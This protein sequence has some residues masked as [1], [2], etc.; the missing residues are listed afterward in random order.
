[1]P[2]WI[3]VRVAPT[4]C[5]SS[6]SARSS[7]ESGRQLPPGILN[8]TSRG[9]GP[10]TVCYLCGHWQKDWEGCWAPSHWRHCPGECGSSGGYEA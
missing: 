10:G 5:T 9:S 6:S 1:M 8:S 4:H 3:R 7:L 2:D